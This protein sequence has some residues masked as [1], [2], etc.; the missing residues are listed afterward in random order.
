M[1]NNDDPKG[2]ANKVQGRLGKPIQ[3]KIDWSLYTKSYGSVPRE[4]LLATIT[5]N[6]LQVKSRVNPELIKQFSD[7]T[8]REN[9]IKTATLQLMS[10]PE[11]QLC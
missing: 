11:Y 10:T 3:V 6:L 4:L 2:G 9:F 7:Q 1:T 8:G 5:D